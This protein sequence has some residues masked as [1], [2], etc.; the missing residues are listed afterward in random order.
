MRWLDESGIQFSYNELLCGAVP[1]WRHFY[2]SNLSL[3]TK[4][5]REN[6]FNESFT[7]AAAED[8]ELGYRLE[9]QCGLEVVFIADALAYH[10]HP[11]SFRQACK[12]MFDVG[13]STRYF[14]DLWPCSTELSGSSRM[15]RLLRNFMM[16]HHQ[17]V[18]PPLT[19]LAELL[20]TVWCPNPLMRDT[21]ASYYR[22]GYQSANVSAQNSP[23]SVPQ[24]RDGGGD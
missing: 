18:L 3:K 14:E 11:T 15:R 1:H 6:P 12:R 23:L 22:L 4:L 20:T 16:N 13:M 17:W 19:S 9:Q 5:L 2:T 10:L 8:I 21:L 24:N 7:K